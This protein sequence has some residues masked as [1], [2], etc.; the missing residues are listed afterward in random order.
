VRHLDLLLAVSHATTPLLFRKLCL[1][2]CLDSQQETLRGTSCTT[3]RVPLRMSQPS[4]S[5]HLTHGT[6]GRFR[7]CHPLQLT[8]SVYTSWI[9]VA[10]PV[11]SSTGTT[12]ASNHRTPRSRSGQGRRMLKNLR[13]YAPKMSCLGVSSCGL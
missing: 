1:K 13:T 8:A 10:L 12:S 9:P 2:P 4:A 3:R 11:L 6:C 7:P 5:P